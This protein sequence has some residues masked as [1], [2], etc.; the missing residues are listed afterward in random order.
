MN[1]CN[2]EARILQHLT[3]LSTK[4]FQNYYNDFQLQEHIVDS[5]DLVGRPRLE[6]GTIGLKVRC[7]TN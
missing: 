4:I 7:S 3:K 5:Y 1:L 2:K 6:R